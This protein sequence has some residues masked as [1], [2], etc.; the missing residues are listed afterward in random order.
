MHELLV[1]LGVELWQVQLAF[2]LGRALQIP[3]PY[4]IDPAMLPG[5]QEQLVALRRA[6]RMSIIV[7]DNIGYYGRLEPLLRTSVG[8]EAT[9]WTGCMAGC[10]GVAIASN[11]DVKGC[12]SHPPSFVV[13]NVRS[14]PFSAIWSDRARFGYNTAWR[15]DLLV[16]ACATCCYRRI[17]RAGCTSMAYAVTGTIYDNPFCVLRA[18]NRP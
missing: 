8:G 12:P 5:L 10:L 4:V 6:G 2:P 16:G 1:Q 7:A 3:V 14:E 9:F 13:G 11:G 17:C 18:S 15:E